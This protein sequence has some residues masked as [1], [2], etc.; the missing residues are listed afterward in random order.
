MASL[1]H[2]EL[3][4]STHWGMP[5]MVDILETTFL[6]A[7]CWHEIFSF[8]FKFHWCFSQGP[9]CQLVCIGSGV[10]FS[11]YRPKPLCAPMVTKMS[12]AKWCHSE[13]IWVCYWSEALYKLT[14]SFNVKWTYY[15]YIQGSTYQKKFTCP[16]SKILHF[17]IQIMYD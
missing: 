12:N 4:L 17:L 15:F 6:N 7:F 1:G 8:W 16:T 2:N 13:L 11:P 5:K 10:G 14:K 3:S 9:N